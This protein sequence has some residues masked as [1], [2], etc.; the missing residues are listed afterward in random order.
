M[1]EIF[2]VTSAVKKI[3]KRLYF[4]FTEHFCPTPKIRFYVDLWRNKIKGKEFSAFQCAKDLKIPLVSAH[5]SL[6]DL[7]K[8]DKILCTKNSNILHKRNIYFKTLFYA[9]H[10]LPFIMMNLWESFSYIDKFIIVE[11]NRT[12]VGE[13]KPFIFMEYISRIPQD[14]RE[15]IL[16]IPA[17]LSK[18][19]VDCSLSNDGAQMHRNEV[20]LCDFFENNVKLM[21][22]DIVISAD[23]D[24]VIYKHSYPLMLHAMEKED[25]L[26]LP[27]HQFF[28]RMNYL[29]EDL[30][31]WAPQVTRASY[32]LFKPFPH[33]W[34]YEGKRFPFIAGCHFSWQLTLDQMIY[35]LNTY[36]H[37]DIYGHFA[38][39]EILRDAVT[40]KIYPFKPDTPFTIQELNSERDKSYYP[41]SFFVFQKEFA[42]LLPPAPIQ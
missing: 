2:L 42:H 23:A 10:E 11:S 26:L 3:M 35:K 40:R 4:I 8:R 38:D 13:S 28:Y 33:Y 31:F 9:P 25:V 7:A 5:I 32:Y 20:A 30:T 1:M 34:R 18:V 29:W 19:S 21:K 37:K 17:D 41:E 27:L 15:K 6:I 36:A 16:Y 12:Y 24:E 14:L 22:D 39:K